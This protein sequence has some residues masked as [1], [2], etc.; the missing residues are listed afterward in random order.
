MN[1]NLVTTSE[2]P[3]VENYQNVLI[4][5]VNNVPLR[6]CK[7]VILNN[8]L[9]YLTHDQFIEVLG[10]VRHGGSISVTA[11]DIVEAASALYWG[12]IDTN[13]FSSLTSNRTQQYSVLDVKNL[14]EQEGYTIEIATIYDLSFHIKA[15]RP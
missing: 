14:F 1:I 13:T 7:N 5:E 4:T 15:H 6:G 11:P 9:N 8:S 3:S 10:K 12:S 2:A